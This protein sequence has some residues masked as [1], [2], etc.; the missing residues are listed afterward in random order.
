MERNPYGS[1][2]LKI[3]KVPVVSRW[4][5]ADTGRLQMC[6]PGRS[7][8]QWIRRTP[9]PDYATACSTIHRLVNRHK[10]SIHLLRL[11]CGYLLFVVV[12]L[13]YLWFLITFVP[14]VS[15]SLRDIISAPLPYGRSAMLFGHCDL[16]WEWREL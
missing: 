9:D 15:E 11:C 14:C 12:Y 13:L 16:H 8:F 1:I 4:R 2:E 6:W 7:R 10:H 5:R 3:C